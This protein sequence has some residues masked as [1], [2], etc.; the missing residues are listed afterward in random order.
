MDNSQVKDLSS[1]KKE[2]SN[3]NLRV[4]NVLAAD[5]AAIGWKEI[6]EIL[7]FVVLVWVVYKWC[8]EKRKRNLDKATQR[9]EETI[10]NNL[11]TIPAV[12]FQPD[13]PG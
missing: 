9:L 4:I 8:C 5:I 3:T 7:S 11:P 2:L 12:T 13:K 1:D 10:Q 6:L